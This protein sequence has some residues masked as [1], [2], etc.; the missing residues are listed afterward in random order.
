MVSVAVMFLMLITKASFAYRTRSPAV[1]RW[2]AVSACSASSS[3]RPAAHA[4]STNRRWTRP[5]AVPLCRRL[6][7]TTFDGRNVDTPPTDPGRFDDN[8]DADVDEGDYDG[9]DDDV[10]EEDDEDGGDGAMATPK[11]GSLRLKVRQHVNPLASTYQKVHRPPALR[12]SA[13]FS[14]TALLPPLPAPPRQP[15]PLDPDWVRHAFAA[16]T[17]PTVVDIGCAKGTW[18]LK[19]GQTTPTKNVLGLEIRRPVV[20]FALERKKRW[21]LS[22][23]HFLSVNANVDLA[24]ILGDLV[25]AGYVSSCPLWPPLLY[26]LAVSCRRRRVSLSPTPYPTLLSSIASARTW[27][28]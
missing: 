27:T 13:A 24:R 15:Q 23:V 21:G 12:A 6:Y 11:E 18:V 19:S 5:H 4:P 17:Q 3:C 10:D 7:A 8:D 20:Q 2:V 9:D 25:A 1:G 28:W 14:L 16:P 26:V 22:N